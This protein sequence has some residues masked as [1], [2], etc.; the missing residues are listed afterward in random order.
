MSLT[1]ITGRVIKDGTLK[2]EDF[3]SGRPDWNSTGYLSATKFFG[4]GSLLAGITATD[5]TPTVINVLTSTNFTGYLTADAFVG[6]GGGLSNIQRALSVIEVTDNSFI[7]EPKHNNC[8]MVLNSLS[9]INIS[10]NAS[11]FFIP[12]HIT[13]FIQYNQ[14]RG[15]FISQQFY[16]AD[17]FYE[18]QKQYAVCNLLNYKS[19]EGWTLYG[20]LTSTSLTSA[21][22][23]VTPVAN[24]QFTDIFAHNQLTDDGY[25]LALS[26]TQL[27]VVG[28]SNQN[29]QLGLPDP[30]ISISTFTKLSGN[31]NKATGGPRVLLALSGQDLFGIGDSVVG[32][33]K[34]D[35]V[36]VSTFTRVSVTR[37]VGQWIGGTYYYGSS[38]TTNPKWTDIYTSSTSDTIAVSGTNWYITGKNYFGVHGCYN[39]TPTYIFHP[40]PGPPNINKGNWSK[41]TLGNGGHALALSGSTIF[42]IGRNHEGQLGLNDVL[43]FGNVN[44]RSTFTRITLPVNAQWTNIFTGYNNSF[45]LSGTDLYACGQNFFGDLGLNDVL[46]RSTFT[47]IPGS[48]GSNIELIQVT[49]YSNFILSGTDLYGCGQNNKG[50]LGLNDTLSRS[51]FTKIPGN[52]NKVVGFFGATAL[53]GNSLFITGPG[54]RGLGD[55][56]NRL[57]FT[58]VTG[59][60]IPQ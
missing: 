14:G 58:Q 15:K 5:I 16:N 44:H 51:T 48:W 38:E 32:G 31:W 39:T 26:G 52:W 20:D 49:P 57:T 18:T 46:A 2:P 50:Q 35:S 41:V 60:A 27:F 17:N 34:I 53:S 36:L 10:V 21:P 59:V 45:A 24:A 43:A 6:D 23:L 13:T 33:L 56:I 3:S 8:I 47:K 7:V 37:A 40:I 55:N 19:L 30:N 29:Y 22:I 4:D 12:G 42:S 25:G 9:T 54:R 28:S 11:P 1:K